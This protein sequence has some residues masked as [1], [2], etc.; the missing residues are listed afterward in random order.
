MRGSFELLNLKPME[1]SFYRKLNIWKLSIE[2]VVLIYEETKKFPSEEKFGLTNQIRR[3]I[4]SVPS[5]IAEG[6]SRLTEKDKLHFLYISSS[7]LAEVETQ[8]IISSKL[9]YVNDL[10][11]QEILQQIISLQK[12]ISSLQ[13]KIRSML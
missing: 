5:N 13:K 9:G 11:F 8:W 10:Q 4:V 12:Q 3:A 7:S 1:Q 6:Y 2:L